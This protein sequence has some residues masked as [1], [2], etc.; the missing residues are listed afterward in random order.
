MATTPNLYL[1]DEPLSN[2]DARLRLEARTFLKQLQTELGVTTIFVT[3]DQSEALAIADRMAVMDKGVVRQVGSPSEFFHRPANLFVAAFIGSTPMNLLEGQVLQG[4]V[5]VG[6]NTFTIPE[7]YRGKLQEG[8]E[9]VYGIRPEYVSVVSSNADGVASGS[10]KV[11]ENMG[12]HYL[13]SID[14]CGTLVRGTV[15]DGQQ[16]DNGATLHFLPDLNK[17]LIYDKV[18]GNLI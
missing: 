8:Q 5:K 1:F 2:L 17:V 7:S 13:V 11:T 9:V 10:V 14:C 18:S 15:P 16:P 4:N 6:S 12:T 3:H